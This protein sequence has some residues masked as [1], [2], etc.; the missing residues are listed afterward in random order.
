MTFLEPMRANILANR[1]RVPPRG[2]AGGGDALPG[3]NWVERADGTIEML[4]ATASAD[5]QPGD[6]FVIE[7][8]GGG[9]YGGG[10]MNYWPL[11]GIAAGRHRLRAP[12]Q[13]DAG[14]HRLGDRHRPPR[15]DGPSRSS[16]PSARR[17]TTT[18]SSPSS[19]SCCRSSAC[20][21]ATACSS[22]GDGDPRHARRHHRA[23]A[24]P[25]FAL[26][27]GDRGDRPARRPPATRRRCGRW[28]RRWR[29]RRPRSSMASS[30]RR[31]RTRSRLC[32]R[33]PTMSACSSARTS[34]S[35]SARS[36]SSSRSGDLRL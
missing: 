33:R 10:R 2:L 20:S 17:S 22:G 31:P 5:I 12:A 32:P 18:A 21:S 6:R 26:P 28:S 35:P 13:P 19:G 16:R 30:T 25:L 34:S 3:R 27:P 15:R 14:R 1:R 24:D 4:S 7:T 29:W 36:S 11:L 9:G 23:A 8:P